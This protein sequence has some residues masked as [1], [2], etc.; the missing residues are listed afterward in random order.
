MQVVFP[1]SIQFEDGEIE[2]YESVEDLELNLEDFD[3]EQD[4]ACSVKDA[5]GRSVK[6]K[7]K[8]LKLEELSL[9]SG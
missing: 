1:L 6:L 3:S 5:Q 9:S 8:F 2:Q 4:I 7:I